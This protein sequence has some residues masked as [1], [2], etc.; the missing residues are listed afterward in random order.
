MD[1]YVSTETLDCLEEV[2]YDINIKLLQEVHKKYL[3]K[4]DFQELVYI[5]EGF[6]K[7]KFKIKFNDECTTK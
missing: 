5:L 4:L 7:K 6:K 2:I 1:F 3:T